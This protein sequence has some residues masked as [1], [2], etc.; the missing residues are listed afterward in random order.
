[1]STKVE[2]SDP[3]CQNPDFEEQFACETLWHITIDVA[4]PYREAASIVVERFF[5]ASRRHAFRD[6]R[7]EMHRRGSGVLVGM[8]LMRRDDAP[9]ELPALLA[10][11][12]DQD[13]RANPEQG[14]GDDEAGDD[15]NRKKVS[16]VHLMPIHNRG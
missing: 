13:A 11:P 16:P 14:A 8:G 2:L 1:M 7:L 15:G 5:V 4:L 6:F 9:V 12:A 3:A 10:E